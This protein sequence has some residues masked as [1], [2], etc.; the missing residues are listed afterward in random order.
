[1][2]LASFFVLSV[3]L[4]A[5]A[6]VY[7]V[8]LPVRERFAPIPVKIL[9]PEREPQ[10]GQGGRG[11]TVAHPRRGASSTNFREGSAQL[12]PEAQLTAP[13]ASFQQSLPVETTAEQKQVP[14]LASVVNFTDARNGA[15]SVDASNAGSR[16][17]ISTGAGG[18]T[19]GS[20]NGLGAT[21]SGPGTGDRDGGGNGAGWVQ[22]RYNDTP[23]PRYPE[24]ARRQ[25]REGRVL[26]RVLVDDHGRTK[27]VEINASSGDQALDRAAVDAVKRW[28]F[29]PARRGNQAVESWLRVP[30]EFRLADAQAW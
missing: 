24:S 26:L 16:L 12:A 5:S 14:V 15:P 17:A 22:A 1:M 11:G 3:T 21:G 20:G 29:H 10:S 28:R 27:S 9:P 18:G 4:H 30:V 6:L 19:A 25:G 23:K 2:R 13:S 8:S 7:P